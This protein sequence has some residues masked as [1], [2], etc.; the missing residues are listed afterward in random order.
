MIHM[1]KFFRDESGQTL[2]LVAL[3][4]AV[5]M[6]FAALAFDVGLMANSRSRLQNAADAAALAGAMEIPPTKTSGETPQEQNAIKAAAETAAKAYAQKNGYPSNVTVSINLVERSVKVTITENVNHV[7]ARVFIKDS[8]VIGA[9]AKAQRYATFGLGSAMPLVNYN[10]TVE[11]GKGIELRVKTGGAE[12]SRQ[13]IYIK[14][15]HGSN[16]NNNFDPTQLKI[17]PYDGLSIEKGNVQSYVDPV[18]NRLLNY[19]GTNFVYSINPQMLADKDSNGNVWI[20]VYEK[21]NKNKPVSVPFPG[22]N[23]FNNSDI[24]TPFAVKNQATGK[25]FP[26]EKNTPGAIEQ[27]VLLEVSGF[28]PMSGGNDSLSGVVQKIYSLYDADNPLNKIETNVGTTKSR[29]I[30]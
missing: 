7:F 25:Y 14:E 8:S 30:E 28:S 22:N 10:S 18:V 16:P 17:D 13:W 19:A 4:M 24:I 2:A 29:L 12:S 26:A 20:A 6:G 27:I 11:L 9:S 1:K 5:I 15:E 23:D 3:A 21:G